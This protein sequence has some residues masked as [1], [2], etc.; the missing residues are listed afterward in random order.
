MLE[1]CLLRVLLG[2]HDRITLKYMTVGHTK[3][4]PDR[5]FGMIRQR[6]KE[7]RALSLPEFKTDMVDGAA[8]CSVGY[9]FDHYSPCRD[10]KSGTSRLFPRLTG[11]RS[12]FFY[13]IEIESCMFEDGEKSARV[14]TATGPDGSGK[15]AKVFKEP[16]TL[17]GLEDPSF[18]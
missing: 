5:L 11:F 7:K 10:Y 16:S 18:F 8:N 12:S 13:S 14:T 9:T 6:M 17:P 4:G 15:S 3:F 1:Y 2:F